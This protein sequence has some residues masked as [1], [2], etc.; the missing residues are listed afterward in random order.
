MGVFVVILS[1]RGKKFKEGRM[2]IY[3]SVAELSQKLRLQRSSVYELT[4][5][6]RIPHFKLGGKLLFSEEDIERWVEKQRVDLSNGG[7]SE[8]NK[9]D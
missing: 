5:A 8:P 7:T 3:L 4:S 9:D 1:L 2:K 6:R